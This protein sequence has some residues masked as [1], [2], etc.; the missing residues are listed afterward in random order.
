[1]RVRARRRRG[2]GPGGAR[3]WLD[4]PRPVARGAGRGHFGVLP[5]LGGLTR[6]PAGLRHARPAFLVA[7][8][9]A[10]AISLGSYAAALPAGAG[11]ARCAGAVRAGG[12]RRPGQLL[13]QSPHPV[14]SAT[15]TLVNTNALEAEGVA[16]ATTGEAIGLTSLTSTVALIALFGTGSWPRPAA[17]SPPYLLI[18]GVALVP[19]RGGGRRAC[20]ASAHRPSPGGPGAGRRT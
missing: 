10:Q 18:A 4:P 8:V 20:S 6:T 17:R 9:V 5:R 11:R 7:A 19:G 12:G 16:A 1:M 2:R 3:P 15:G 14:G 13:R